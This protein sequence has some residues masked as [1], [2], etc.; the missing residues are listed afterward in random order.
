MK[1]VMSDQSIISALIPGI[2]KTLLSHGCKLVGDGI[3]T[4]G[5]Q[6]GDEVILIDMD[7]IVAHV[8]VD[9]YSG[10][11][12]YLKDIVWQMRSPLEFALEWWGRWSRDQR[13]VQS[14]VH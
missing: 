8:R 5:C 7:K 9:D 1:S 14:E 2:K 12:A 11:A 10:M 3:F 6:R 4:Y 13:R